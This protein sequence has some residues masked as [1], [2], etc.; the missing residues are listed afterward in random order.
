MRSINIITLKHNYRMEEKQFN[1]SPNVRMNINDTSSANV[2]LQKLDAEYQ[3]SA[4]PTKP[5]LT[6]RRPGN[7]DLLANPSKRVPSVDNSPQLSS[8]LGGF[9]LDTN[10]T[11]RALNESPT[12]S[13]PPSIPE[14]HNMPNLTDMEAENIIDNEDLRNMLDNQQNPDRVS[15]ISV[16]SDNVNM[17][18]PPG[19]SSRYSVSS[20]DLMQEK[21]DLL[22]KFEKLKRKGYSVPSFNMTSD[23][24]DMRY[25]YEKRVHDK[26]VESGVRF[27]RKLLTAFVTG[28]E[29][30][31]NKFDP[32]DIELDGWSENVNENI[33]DYDEVF[34]ELY[35]KYK[36]RAKMAPE[37]KLLMMLGGSAVMFH[38]SKTLFKSSMPGMEDIMKQN[39]DLMKSFASAAMQQMSQNSDNPDARV[40]ANMMRMGQPQKPRPQSTPVRI[41]PPQGVDE[42]LNELKNENNRTP[43][44]RP[45]I[46]L[47][48]T[49]I[50]R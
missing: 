27:Q 2:N 33:D 39:P 19:M 50:R 11:T 34:E 30:L 32:F 8:Q 17:G 35:E 37:L 44:R 16:L 25:E 31:N 36:D 43:I 38:L 47:G 22:Y 6:D 7:L 29:F 46:S 42:I 20:R 28:V 3:P 13:P 1:L 10:Q 12:N 24:D 40:M 14:M 49:A 9:N 26:K 4:P 5:N 18:P 23:L 41:P 48:R 21:Q 45:D 15:R